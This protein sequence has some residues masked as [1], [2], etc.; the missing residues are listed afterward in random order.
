MPA[1]L[2]RSPGSNLRHSAFVKMAAG[3]GA[4]D[5]AWTGRPGLPRSL[6]EAE[7]RNHLSLAQNSKINEPCTVTRES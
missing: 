4:S 6:N 1:N 7:V 2:I 3:A 5:R